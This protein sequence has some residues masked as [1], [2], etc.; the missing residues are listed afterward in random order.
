MR[1]G[2]R[3]PDRR[4]PRCLP[5]RNRPKPTRPRRSRRWPARPAPDRL[6]RRPG[7]R[8]RNRPKPT[9]PKPSPPRRNRP[10]P[11]LS[12]PFLWLRDR[13]RPIPRRPGRPGARCAGRSRSHLPRRNRPRPVHRRRGR[14]RRNRPKRNRVARTPL[15]CC[16]S[17]RRWPTSR[18]RRHPART[19]G[20]SGRRP[21]PDA[22]TGRPP[23]VRV[24]RWALNHGPDRVRN[25]GRRTSSSVTP[26]RSQWGA[27]APPPGCRELGHAASLTGIAHCLQ[28]FRE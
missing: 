11:N 3:W 13:R 1:S 2:G 19:S 28:P 25:W 26:C 9:R 4:S 23:W 6:R 17:S 5:R 15:R 14:P 10:K 27:P 24:R 20:R 12:T 16:R 21:E 22:G 7:P 8:M 18:H